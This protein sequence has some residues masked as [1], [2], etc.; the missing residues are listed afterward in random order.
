MAW[1]D[2]LLA[3]AGIARIDGMASERDDV[4]EEGAWRVAMEVADTTRAEY[5]YRVT[6]PHAWY[7]L[8][9]RSLSFTP[10]RGSFTPGTPV[11]LV[12]LER[13]ARRARPSSPAPSLPTWCARA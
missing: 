3:G 5:L 9:L 13:W 2:P 1:R 8:A 4:D 7:F 12:L 6:T 10:A 11:G